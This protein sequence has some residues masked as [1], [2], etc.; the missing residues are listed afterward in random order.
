MNELFQRNS[1][2][3]DHC[4]NFF[5]RAFEFRTL[6]PDMQNPFP[7]TAR[8]IKVVWAPIYCTQ[9]L[10]LSEDAACSRIEAA[11]ACRRFPLILDLLGSGELTL[12]AVRLLGRNL[13]AENHRDVLAKAKGRSRQQIEVLVAELTPRPDVPTSVRRLPTAIPTPFSSAIPAEAP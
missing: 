7:Q 9:A 13:T 3:V 2:R 8:C 12:T 6:L 11:R 1:A 5:S 4:H 10:R